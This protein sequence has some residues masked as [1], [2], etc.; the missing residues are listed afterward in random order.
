MTGLTWDNEDIEFRNNIFVGSEVRAVGSEEMIRFTRTDSSGLENNAGQT[1][2]DNW[3]FDM[4]D[5]SVVD[6]D[7][8]IY[9]RSTTGTNTLGD[10]KIFRMG[11]L[12]LNPVDYDNVTDF[13]AAFSGQEPSTSPLSIAQRD[14]NAQDTNGVLADYH[15]TNRD[16]DNDFTPVGVAVGAGEA[17]PTNLRTLIGAPV[18]STPDI[19]IIMP[20]GPETPLA[21]SGGMTMAFGGMV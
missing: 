5:T 11:R 2:P 7:R 21:T 9:V 20:V 15:L 1:F 14:I 4:A 10:G 8:N 19:G 13:N 17:L 6:F 3:G 18:D 12:N 16:Y